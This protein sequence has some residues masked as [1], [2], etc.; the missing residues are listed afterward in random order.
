M[1]NSGIDTSILEE[2]VAEGELVE[3]SGMIDEEQLMTDLND[4]MVYLRRSKALLDYVKDQALYKVVEDKERMVMDNLSDG[5]GEFI[6]AIESGYG[7]IGRVT[8]DVSV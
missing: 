6:D 2:S 7:D 1:E 4:A 3:E 8:N 5:I